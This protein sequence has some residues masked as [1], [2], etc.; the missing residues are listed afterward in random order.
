MSGSNHI[1]CVPQCNSWAKRTHCKDVSFH[2]FPKENE[3][4]V[5]VETKLGLKEKVDR[6]KAWIN[7]LK[8]GKPVTKFMKVCSLHFTK[9]DY[10]NTGKSKR[11]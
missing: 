4:K 7:L 8:I 3:R 5:L 9:D 10:F 1:C 11:L 2:L 6:R